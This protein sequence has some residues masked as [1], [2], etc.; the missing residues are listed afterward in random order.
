MEG[1]R[2]ISLLLAVGIIFMPIIFSW[3]TLRQGYSTLVRVVSV[4]W[5]VLIFMS[6]A[7]S[8]TSDVADEACIDRIIDKVENTEQAESA[9]N[10][11][12][13][14]EV[15]NKESAE[16]PHTGETEEEITVE[17]QWN[18]LTPDNEA[19]KPAET[20]KPEAAE[21]DTDECIADKHLIDATISCKRD[22]ERLAQYDHEWEDGF[23]TPW[24]S[25][26][27]VDKDDRN[28]ISY[29]GDA[30]KFQNG[31]GAWQNMIYMCVYD[32]ATGSVINVAVEPG[33][34]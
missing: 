9:E 11:E 32:G 5:M 24:S 17:L 12:A 8:P 3:V 34:L 19:A 22:I 29:F 16:K 2:Q 4:V 25:H 1:K 14:P 26:F 7:A 18:E 6:I 10:K 27:N 21:C 33:K 13:L 28:K 20:P 30:A 31:F 23:F 15:S